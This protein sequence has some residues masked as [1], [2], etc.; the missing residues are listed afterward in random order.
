MESHLTLSKTS[1]D[2]EYF[3]GGSLGEMLR[4]LCW[5]FPLTYPSSLSAKLVRGCLGRLFLLQTFL[6]GIHIRS[7]FASL[8]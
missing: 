2:Q 4:T 1:V 7:S 8:K 6:L 3:L 5:G